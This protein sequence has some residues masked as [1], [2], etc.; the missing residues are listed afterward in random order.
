MLQ[1][2]LT[3]IQKFINGTVSSTIALVILFQD[4][5]KKSKVRI[6]MYG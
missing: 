2:P 1:V 4:K 3:E 5:E 6:E